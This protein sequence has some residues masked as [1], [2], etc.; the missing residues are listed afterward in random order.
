MAS[1]LIAF[2][3]HRFCRSISGSISAAAVY[4][5]RRFLSLSPSGSV[6]LLAIIGSV[7]LFPRATGEI[8][9][10]ATLPLLL[11]LHFHPPPAELSFGH[12]NPSAIVASL[13]GSEV[14]FSGSDVKFSR[15]EEEK[16]E[17]VR[18][19]NMC[20][21]RETGDK[22][23]LLLKRGRRIGRQAE[24]MPMLH[25]TVTQTPTLIEV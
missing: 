13:L 9:S 5:V 8:E 20:A 22:A 1:G 17:F 11:R 24:R 2:L 18:R 14:P 6:R 7:G 3:L 15:L 10:A 25:S 4:H 19:R 23:Y 12:F 21:R 16:R